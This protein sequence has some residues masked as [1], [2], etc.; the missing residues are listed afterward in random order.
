MSVA[1]TVSDCLFFLIFLIVFR[2]ADRNKFVKILA[3]NL[4]QSPAVKAETRYNGE[5]VVLQREIPAS[6]SKCSVDIKSN[7]ISAI[8]SQGQWQYFFFF[9]QMGDV[10]GVTESTVQVV[11][12]DGNVDSHTTI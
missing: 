11:R 9:T 5:Q 6:I 7:R 3:D 8:R 12:Y 10:N 1:H 2:Y 4:K